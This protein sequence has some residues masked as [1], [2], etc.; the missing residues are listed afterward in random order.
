MKFT[1][2]GTP[3]PQGSTRAFIPKGWKRPI[4]TAANSKTKP[5]R[6]EIANTALAHMEQSGY[7]I[8]EVGPVE[9]SAYFFFERPKSLKRA[10]TSKTTKPDID[11]L[12]RA[13]Q[14]ALTGIAF[15]D[16]AQ[17]TAVAVGKTFGSPARVEIELR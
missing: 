13:L 16:D 3:V 7:E 4:I 5:W 6:Q 11:K 1:V 2:Y 10:V 9:L 17:I 12:L 15:K 14:D 8:R